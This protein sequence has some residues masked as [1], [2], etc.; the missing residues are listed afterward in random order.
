MLVSAMLACNSLNVVTGL[1]ANSLRYKPWIVASLDSAV[2]PINWVNKSASAID[3]SAIR[4]GKLLMAIEL[5]TFATSTLCNVEKRTPSFSTAQLMLSLAFLST[6]RS[7]IMVKLE[8]VPWYFKLT[9]LLSPL[10]LATCRSP[11][12]SS[13]QVILGAVRGDN[14]SRLNTSCHVP[15]FAVTTKRAVPSWFTLIWSIDTLAISGERLSM[16]TL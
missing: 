15:S 8:S 12:L 13:C 2:S 11:L 10:M 7:V 1:L 14:K 4:A 6:D 9:W 3:V 16:V 5:T